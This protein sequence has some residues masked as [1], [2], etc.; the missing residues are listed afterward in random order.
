MI[1]EK[2]NSIDVQR[3]SVIYQNGTHHINTKSTSTGIGVGLGGDIGIGVADTN[4]RGYT[5]S[6]LAQRVAPPSKN[7]SSLYQL[8]F[9]IG[10]I[11]VLFWR[12]LDWKLILGIIIL[13]FGFKVYKTTKNYNKKIY[14][15]KYNEWLNSWH[16]NKCGNIYQD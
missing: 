2:C 14:P 1:C 5:Q 13:L 11:L 8:A 10:G 12:D 3:L 6:L 7:I 16:C 9:I 4:T 15:K